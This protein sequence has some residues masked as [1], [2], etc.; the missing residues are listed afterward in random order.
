MTVYEPGRSSMSKIPSGDVRA[1]VA[2]P[3]VSLKYTVP[4]RTLLL[5]AIPPW[6]SS[7][8]ETFAFEVDTSREAL[9]H[10]LRE[11]NISIAALI[12]VRLFIWTSTLQL[13]K[14]IRG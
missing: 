11:S 13:E 5:C 7:V 4:G 3:A 12:F 14:F 2:L 1:L 6:Y 10:P 9:P 8:P